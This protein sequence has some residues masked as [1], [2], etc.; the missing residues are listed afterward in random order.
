M[1]IHAYTDPGHGWGKVSESQLKRLGL[2]FG[3]FSGCSY[4]R[5]EF[6][7]L[8][9]DADLSYFI[10]KHVEVLGSKPTFKTHV[11]NKTSRIR[12]YA[13]NSPGET[14]RTR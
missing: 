3:D 10:E 14:Y 8:E 1:H 13:C 9:E 5:G 12:N 2:T 11:G 4:R 7:Y 6:I